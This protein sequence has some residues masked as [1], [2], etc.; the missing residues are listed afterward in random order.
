MAGTRDFTVDEH[1]S[2]TSYRMKSDYHVMPY[3]FSIP[4]RNPVIVRHTCR[5]CGDELSL[6]VADDRTLVKRQLLL[7]VLYV[8]GS[9]GSLY[10]YNRAIETG[11]DLHWTAAI[12]LTIAGT[13]LC[14]Y[15]SLLIGS[16]EFE[17]RIRIK[18]GNTRFEIQP[19]TV[20]K[21]R[22]FDPN[23][24]A[25]LPRRYV[26]SRILM[27][28][29]FLAYLCLFYRIVIDGKGKEVYETMFSLAMVIGIGA[30]IMGVLN[31]VYEAVKRIKM[32]RGGQKPK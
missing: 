9:S 5:L 12:V 28:L 3:E 21:H 10:F 1:Y 27:V 14:G 17:N 26:L 4:E 13:L 7:P 6:Q 23:E 25:P 20:R 31:G 2:S 29:S 32:R 19:F 8:L 11:N 30:V 18:S 24:K 16:F 22:L 15:L